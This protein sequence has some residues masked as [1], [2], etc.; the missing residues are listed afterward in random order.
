MTRM[1]AFLR[2]INVGGHTVKM[3][4]LRALFEQLGFSKVETFIASGNVIFETLEENSTELS[5]KI[6]RQLFQGLGYEVASFLRTPAE[7]AEIARLR[8]FDENQMFAAAA[9]NVAFLRAPLI[10]SQKLALRQF[11][12]GLDDFAVVGREVFWLSRVKQSQS[13]FSNAALEKALK[14][15]STFRGVN[16]IKRLAQI[17][18]ST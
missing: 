1:I 5:E 9:L 10:E 13:K 2:A 11:E 14:I 6:E 3:E 8:P 12:T 7:V 4:N 15:R 18:P 16:T 17:Y